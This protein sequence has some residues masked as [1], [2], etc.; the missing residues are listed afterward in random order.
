MNAQ[1]LIVL[2]FRILSPLLPGLAARL[3]RRLL[4][5]PRVHPM[6]DWE[7]A[8]A[9]AEIL[10]FGE[11]LVARRW[12]RGPHVLLLHGWSGRYT[13]FGPLIEALVR[14]GFA[15]IAIDP[16]AHG[17]SPGRESHPI[18]FADAL[19]D[20][21][22][23]F[24]PVYAVIGHSMGAGAAGFTLANGLEVE[25]AV[26]IGGP[27]SMSR[28][29]ERFSAAIGLS[30]TARAMLFERVGRHMGVAEH[31]LDV[32]RLAEPEGVRVLLVHD[33][34][35]RD[36]PVAEAHAIKSAWPR[37]ELH[38]TRGLG[39]RRLLSDEATIRRIVGFVAAPARSTA[40]V[41]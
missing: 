26:L 7:K 19:F 39:H 6:Q 15:P 17:N 16:P 8:P 30:R 4:M 22:E 37:S 18:A 13:Q 32:E 25:R 11:G 36:V 3:A 9:G 2:G 5:T 29:L 12:G 1:V 34:D 41:R 14:A 20:A 28:V 23:A 35:D 31:D 27:A 10:R 38:L 33:E 24:A 21:A 40:F